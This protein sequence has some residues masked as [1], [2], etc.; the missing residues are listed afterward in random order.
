MA[1]AVDVHETDDGDLMIDFCECHASSSAQN[2]VKHFLDFNRSTSYIGKYNDPYVYAK[3]FT[4]FFLHHFDEVLKKSSFTDECFLT[5]KGDQSKSVSSQR[6][7]RQSEIGGLDSENIVNN[8]ADPSSKSTKR[9]FRRFSLKNIRKSSRMFLRPASV[10]LKSNVE[11]NRSHSISRKHGHINIRK[12]A[13]VHPSGGDGFGVIKE[14]IVHV[15][16]VDDSKGKSKWQK[17]RLVLLRSSIG[18]LLEFYTPP[19]ASIV[20]LCQIMF[21]TYQTA[22]AENNAVFSKMYVSNN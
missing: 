5:E 12:E 16:N 13:N 3:K 17:C 8:G 10:D 21:M 22:Y 7:V 6:W 9:I 18:Y 15:L 20:V 14:G 2:F 1:S 4:E 11:Q 19:K